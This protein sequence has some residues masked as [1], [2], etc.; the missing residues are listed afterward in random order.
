M[1]W[2]W[3]KW[4]RQA[5]RQ[6]EVELIQRLKAKW[7]AGPSTLPICPPAEFGAQPIEYTHP[8]KLAPSPPTLV[9]KQPFSPSPA[10]LQRPAMKNLYK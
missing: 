2:D 3:Q 5:Q 4:D 8:W 10:C 1:R 9:Q 6:T 7:Q